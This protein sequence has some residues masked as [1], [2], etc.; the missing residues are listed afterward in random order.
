[1]LYSILDKFFVIFHTAIIILN[2]FGWIWKKTRR[3]NLALLLLTGASWSLLGIFYGWGYCPFT[4]WH[5]R[6]L[7]KMGETNLPSS[8]VQYLGERISGLQFNPDK[9]N[10]IT[11][12]VFLACLMISLLLNVLDY[13]RKA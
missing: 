4:D 1:M 8:Y 7:E 6:V 5:F 13:R 3:A 2:V 9:V 11:L 12:Y 10:D